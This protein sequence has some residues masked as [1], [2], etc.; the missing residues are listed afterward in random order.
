MQKLLFLFGG[1]YAFIFGNFFVA[2]VVAV[3]LVDGSGG[4]EI[5]TR[6]VN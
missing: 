3:D 5:Q 6:Q 4:N 1:F 2:V